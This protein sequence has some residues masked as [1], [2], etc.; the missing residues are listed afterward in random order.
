[1]SNADENA[2]GEF[3][4]AAES[5]PLTSNTLDMDDPAYLS[6]MLDRVFPIIPTNDQYLA[7]SCFD[8]SQAN[9]IINEYTFTNSAH[10][11]EQ[12]LIDIV[13]REFKPTVQML[14]Q[15]LDVK[16][17]QEPKPVKTANSENSSM[18]PQLDR[19]NR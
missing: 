13:S 12:F 3:C 11:N 16:L 5:E 14:E 7:P 1:M 8:D 17:M 6:E 19:H 4:T 9:Q 15:S 2:F 10:E 18:V